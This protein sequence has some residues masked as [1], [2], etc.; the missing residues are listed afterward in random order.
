MKLK[1]IKKVEIRGERVKKSVFEENPF[2]IPSNKAIV[3]KKTTI[4]VKPDEIP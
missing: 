1:Y 4:A 3:K 2:K